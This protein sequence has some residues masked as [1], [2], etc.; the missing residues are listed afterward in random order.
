MSTPVRACGTTI[1]TLLAAGTLMAISPC[2]FS[3]DEDSPGWSPQ[4]ILPAEPWKEQQDELPAYPEKGNLLDTNISTGGQAYKVYIDTQSV[5]PGEDLVVRYT[6][7]MISSSGV[8]NVSNE[9]LHCGERTYRRYA[10]G[11]QGK[12]RELEGSQWKP[13]SGL[14]VNQYRRLFYNT[15]MCNQA[16]PYQDARE[17]IRKFRSSD[18]GYEE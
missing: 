17:I 16:E 12:W 7:V 1:N 11:Y 3:D 18:Y 9:G 10:Y 4:H 13:V 14:G 15:Y 6:V 8:W 5:R 2:V